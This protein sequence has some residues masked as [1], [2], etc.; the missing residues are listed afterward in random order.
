M[1]RDYVWLRWIV[2]IIFEPMGDMIE[3]YKDANGFYL[4]QGTMTSGQKLQ[5]L[6]RYFKKTNRQFF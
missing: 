2:Y 5:L 3:I 4:N 6:K 1:K